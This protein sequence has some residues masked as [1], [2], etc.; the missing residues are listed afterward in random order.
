MGQWVVRPSPSLLLFIN[1][2]Y[3]SNRRKKIKS[4][5]CKKE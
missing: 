4:D 1:L 3:V 2:T 5:T